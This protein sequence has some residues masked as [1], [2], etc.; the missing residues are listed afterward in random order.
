LGDGPWE[1]QAMALAIEFQSE[2]AVD[3]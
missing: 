1:L 2:R 3:T